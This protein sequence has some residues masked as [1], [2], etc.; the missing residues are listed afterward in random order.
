MRLFPVA[1][2]FPLKASPLKAFPL[3]AFPLKAFPLKAF[4]KAFLKA[5]PLKCLGRA[6]DNSPQTQTSRT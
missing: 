1:K 2:A 5:C 3:K 4:L 6:T